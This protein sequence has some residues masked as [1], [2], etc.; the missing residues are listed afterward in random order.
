MEIELNFGM[1]FDVWSMMSATIRM[2]G[3]GG[4]S[5]TLEKPWLLAIAAAVSILGP[6]SQKFVS[7]RL[8]PHP[9]FGVLIG[10]LAVAIVLETG[11]GQPVTF[12]Y[13]QF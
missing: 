7:E 13:F 11:K 4:F 1:C 10:L 3:A 12:I 5:P 6:T 2:L 8:L 9:V